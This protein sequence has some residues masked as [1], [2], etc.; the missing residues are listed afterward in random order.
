[1][2]NHQHSECI[3][4]C[5]ECAVECDECAAACLREDDVKM[6]ARCIALDMD[7]AAM[8]QLAVATMARGSEHAGPICLLCADIC[9]SCAVE[10]SKHSMEH[11]KRCAEA[12]RRCAKACREMAT[13]IAKSSVAKK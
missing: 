4:A 10:C 8:C 2:R 9:D 12:C 13:S 7:C 11:C 3:L 6:M 5:N 1:M